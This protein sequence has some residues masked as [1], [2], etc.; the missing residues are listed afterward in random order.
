MEGTITMSVEA[1]SPIARWT[2]T[3]MPLASPTGPRSRPDDRDL[4]RRRLR[5]RRID[6][7]EHAKGIQDIVDAGQRRDD[8]IREGD[9]AD[10]ERSDFAAHAAPRGTNE[11]FL[12]CIALTCGR[13]N[14]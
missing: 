6:A 14:A 4:E 5:D 10:L 7:R 8:G 13:G 9:Q 1:I 2:S 3:D 12:A 11:P